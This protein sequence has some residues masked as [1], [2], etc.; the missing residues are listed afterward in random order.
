MFNI[1]SLAGGIFGGPVGAAVGGSLFESV[2]GKGAMDEMVKGG[3][4]IM[5]MLLQPMLND[6]LSDLGPEEE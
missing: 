2:L 1:G 4:G 6:L 3:T 5:Q